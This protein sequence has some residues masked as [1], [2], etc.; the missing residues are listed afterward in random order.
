M[1]QKVVGLA[2]SLHQGWRGVGQLSCIVNL[3]CAF[4]FV[5]SFPAFAQSQDL[6]QRSDFRPPAPGSRLPLEPSKP[7]FSGD[8]F[9]IEG[10]LAVGSQYL[11]DEFNQGANAA[12][13]LAS[14]MRYSFLKS[15]SLNAE[16][17]MTFSAERFQSQFDSDDFAEG[18][19]AR[20]FDLV[21]KPIK[22]FQLG[23]GGINQKE[24]IW[25]P[26]LL[27][28]RAFPGAYEQINIV[29]DHN[30]EYCN[31][32]QVRAGQFLPTSRSFDTDRQEKE[33]D[34][35]LSTIG[36][37]G[38]L[39][40]NKHI[41]FTAHYLNFRYENLPSVVAFR[42]RVR[43][44]TVLGET[45][46]NSL[47]AFD[48]SGYVAGGTINLRP[49]DSVAVNFHFQAIE[50]EEAPESVNSGRI[51]WVQPIIRLMKSGGVV[52][53]PLAGAY[54]NEPDTAPGFYSWGDLGHNNREGTFYGLDIDFN[55]HNFRLRSKLVQ[56]DL[57]NED[58][59][60]FQTNQTYAVITLETLYVTF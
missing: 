37:R 51:A 17:F 55:N 60:N 22:Y 11:T 25:A 50:N 58:D 18:L 4:V 53:K 29:G 33:P 31:C 8:D 13:G 56:A 12:F 57:I 2:M 3:F 1:N 9:Q 14:R 16:A 49:T 38:M 43:G 52:L 30:S 59:F 5:A 36:V 35:F 21:F 48:F 19:R 26:L 46:P 24:F 15:L 20:Q 32:L 7:K 47:F 23:A 34:P 45:A 6:R 28:N 42:S 41:S 39:T 10:K 54:Y 44:N 40:P 27:S